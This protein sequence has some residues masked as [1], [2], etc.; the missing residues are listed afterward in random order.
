MHPR[1]IAR[2]SSEAAPDRRERA[3]H[4]GALLHRG[5]L[6]KAHHGVDGALGLRSAI[7]TRNS[8]AAPPHITAAPSSTGGYPNRASISP[9]TVA[10]IACP[11]NITRKLSAEAFPRSST[12]APSMSKVNIPGSLMYCAIMYAT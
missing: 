6:P 12:V 11:A 9:A 8:S 1:G 3:P 10:A 2:R 5:D 4:L 7:R